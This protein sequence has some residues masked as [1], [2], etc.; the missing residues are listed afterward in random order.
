[1]G[2]SAE[3]A[4]VDTTLTPPHHPGDGV[5]TRNKNDTTRFL[6]STRNGRSWNAIG[7]RQGPSH[8]PH[9]TKFNS[10]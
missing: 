8:R 2:L 3:T 7:M 9:S 1:M 10:A 6:D 5:D 4:N